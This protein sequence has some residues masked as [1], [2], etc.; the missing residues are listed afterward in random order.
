MRKKLFLLLK[1]F[2]LI[3]IFAWILKSVNINETIKVLSRT[4]FSCFLL[5]FLLTNFSNII[6]TLKW[7]RLAKPL[8][9]KSNFIELLKLNYISIFYSIFVPGQASGELIKGL[10]LTKKEGEHEKV[11]IPILIDKVT[12]LLM[13]FLIGFVAILYDN[14]FNRNPSL[15]FSVSF[16]T[17][18][19]LFITMILFSEKT[20]K[21]VGLFKIKNF[22]LNYFESY[23]K[24]NLL[25]LETFIWSFLVKLP[26]IF[27]FYFLAL[28]L[29]LGLSL[30]QSA[31]LFSIVSIAS[32]LPISFS[33]LGVREGT[34]LVLF[35]KLGIQSPQALSFSML[36]FIIG[37]ISGLIG[38]LIELFATVKSHHK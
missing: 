34:V 32:L 4:N 6:L 25:M 27:S 3:A 11:W 20:N 5:A 38:G 37:I 13:I 35:S 24:N 18:V 8:K 33:G 19:L 12:N 7:Q 22:S 30:T 14:S 26:H 16:L 2:L 9:I 36:I 1:L 31:W 21:F 17:A 23:K 29:K 15:I 10:K 28:G